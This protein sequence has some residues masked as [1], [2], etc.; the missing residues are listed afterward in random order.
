V[1]EL[2]NTHTYIEGSL[3]HCFIVDDNLAQ[4]GFD[5]NADMHEGSASKL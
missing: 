2:A 4:E 3:C 5:G 1:A